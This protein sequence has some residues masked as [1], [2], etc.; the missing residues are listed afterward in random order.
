MATCAGADGAEPDEAGGIGGSAGGGLDEG[1]KK[2]LKR[3][4][5]PFRITPRLTD[6]L[7]ILLTKSKCGGHLACRYSRGSDRP[8]MAVR[9]LEWK[10]KWVKQEVPPAP[11]HFSVPRCNGSVCDAIDMFFFPSF[12]LVIA[13][14]RQ[15]NAK[16]EKIKFLKHEDRNSILKLAI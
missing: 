11:H 2:R 14:Q 15:R 5:F 16:D 4:I 13:Q 10:M 3:L 9:G 7:I 6:E 12:L 8:S 1:R